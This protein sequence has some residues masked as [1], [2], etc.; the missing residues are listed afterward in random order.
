[1]LPILT[2]WPF[3]MTAPFTINTP[4]G[5]SINCTLVPGFSP[6]F[7]LKVAGIVTWP[8][9]VIFIAEMSRNN[10][11]NVNIVDGRLSG[12]KRDYLDSQYR[13][14]SDRKGLAVQRTHRERLKP[15]IN[16]A[17]ACR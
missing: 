2:C 14:K 4:L 10:L 13:S 5:W 9:P 15:A 12:L 6:C 3:E 16:H 1:A 8:L 17:V 11:G 7:L